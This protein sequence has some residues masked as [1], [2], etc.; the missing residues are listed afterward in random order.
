MQV[1]QPGDGN[2]FAAQKA[3]ERLCHDFPVARGTQ[4][5][6][7]PCAFVGSALAIY[8]LLA[9]DNL[10]ASADELWTLLEARLCNNSHRRALRLKFNM[11]RW[12]DGKE[13]V[14]EFAT[15]VRSAALALPER[16]SDEVLVDRFVQSLPSNMRNLAL[17]ISGSFDEVTARVS[18]MSLVRPPDMTKTRFR[19]ERV[20]HAAESAGDDDTEAIAQ[21]PGS[22]LTGAPYMRFENAQCYHCGKRGHIARGCP[23]KAKARQENE[24][25]VLGKEKGSAP[26]RSA[27]PP[28]RN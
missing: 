2:Y 14:N 11:L 5:R 9:A 10:H 19:S 22:P 7:L 27:R 24:N 20:Q 23:E 28:L 6:L 4:R 25:R 18:M 17:S 1:T 26:G 16:I 13:T 15:R 8:E 3:W 12:R 21:V